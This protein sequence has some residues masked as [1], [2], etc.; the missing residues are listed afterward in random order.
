M[1]AEMQAFADVVAQAIETATAPLLARVAVL[2]KRQLTH[3][4]DGR[5][6]KDAQVDLDAIA[7]KAAALVPRPRDGV[8]GA[9]GPPVDIESVAVKAASLIPSPANGSDGASFSVGL[10]APSFDGKP[11]DSYMDVKTGEIYQWR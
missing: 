2:E 3:G 6:G 9:Q 10:G 8:D 5:D 7:M 4:R 1:T 11:G